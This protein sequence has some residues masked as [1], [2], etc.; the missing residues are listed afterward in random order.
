MPML[1]NRK[2]SITNDVTSPGDVT[3]ESDTDATGAGDVIF[4][5]GG[6]ERARITATG[7]ATGFTNL[8]I[9]GNAA[10]YNAVPGTGA[11]QTAHIA[12][13]IAAA[14]AAGVTYVDLRAGIY[15]VVDLTIPAHVVVRMVGPQRGVLRQLADAAAGS[16]VVI[17]QGFAGL[18]GSGK[19]L[20]ADGVPVGFGLEN[21]T[22]DGNNVAGAGQAVK[23]YGKRLWLKNVVIKGFT[24]GGLYTECGYVGGQASDDDMPESVID[25]LWIRGGNGHGW[26]NR[27]CHDSIVGHVVIGSCQTGGSVYTS[28][29]YWAR[30]DGATY[31]GEI[32]IESMHTYACDI[33]AQL[34]CPQDIDYLQTESNNEQGLIVTSTQVNI[35]EL[36]HYKNWAK[37]AVAGTALANPSVDLQ[38]GSGGGTIGVHYGSSDYGGTGLNI[39][40]TWTIEGGLM[41]GIGTFQG[42]GLAVTGAHCK[43]D[44]QVKNYSIAGS[45]GCEYAAGAVAHGGHVDLSVSACDTGIKETTA[46]SNRVHF[47]ANV[48][49]CTT[50]FNVTFTGTKCFIVIV[51]DAAG[52]FVRLPSVTVAPTPHDD[53]TQQIGSALLRFQRLHSQSLHVRVAAGDA[54]PSVTVD[55]AGISAGAGGAGALDCV[56][57]RGGAG[58]WSTNQQIRAIDGVQTKYLSGAGKITVVDG[59]FAVAPANGTVA[60]HYD[61]TAGKAYLSVRANG[62]WKVMAGPI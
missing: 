47:F 9:D 56:L 20:V 32:V 54:N 2:A 24:G 44:L 10:P 41:D 40:D 36:R 15:D 59:D 18:T 16:N 8:S 1:L 35:G 45:I 14:V 4:K 52:D 26:E 5:S 37:D 29:G 28:R 50:P 21:C 34:D 55:G 49:A 53:N 30:T 61:T 23:L 48:Q 6:V 38:A 27:G 43:I 13:A 51:T 17:S 3:I 25:P 62:A 57:G 12:A 19:W 7:V 31:L 42:R 33:G 58:F 39:A 46:N 60:V 11:D 22:V